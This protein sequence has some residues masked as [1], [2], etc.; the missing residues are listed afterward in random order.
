MDVF[1]SYIFFFLANDTHIIHLAFV[2]PFIF[3]HFVFELASVG[4]VV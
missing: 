1:F 2:V 3:E 4:L